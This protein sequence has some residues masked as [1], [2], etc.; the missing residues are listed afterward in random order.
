MINNLFSIFDPSTSLFCRNNWLSIILYIILIPY[1][2]WAS[3]SLFLTSWKILFK[4]LF[5]EVRNNLRSLKKKFLFFLIIIFT[6]IIY[7]NF[8]GL[9]PYIFTPSSHL[10]FTIFYSFPIWLSLMSF[11][12]LNK[13]SIIIIHLVPLGSPLILSFFIVLIETVR[14]L[15]RPITLSIRLTANIIRGHLLLHLLSSIIIE[16]HSFVLISFIIF[17]LLI[18]ETAV[19]LIQSFVFITLISLY[20]NEI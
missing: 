14:N 11:G 10:I 9:F 12:L 6:M 3:S 4:K 7:N 20:I 2:F 15:I 1:T 8:F 5:Q 19:A 13:F 16:W 17:L 18:L